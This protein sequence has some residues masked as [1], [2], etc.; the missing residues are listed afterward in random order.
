MRLD[1]FLVILFFFI[2]CQTKNTEV[3]K[4]DLMYS[5]DTININS[6]GRTL[7]LNRFLVV[8]DLD[9][10]KESIFSYNEFDHS[11]DEIDLNKLEFSNNYLFDREGSNG[12]GEYFL[13]FNLLKNNFFFIKSYNKSAV[14]DT[15]GVIV[16]KID[17]LNSVYSNG[18][19]YNDYPSSEIIIGTN[20]LRV[21]GL[22]YDN[23]K[24]EVYVDVLSVNRNIVK[25]L[26]LNFKKS[27]GDLVLEVDNSS[28]FFDPYVYLNT[29][30]NLVI[31]SHEF[32]NE[33]TLLSPN[34]EY[35]RT[36]SYV[37]NMTP[38][39]VKGFNSIKITSMEQLKRE[40]QY[41]LEQVE[42]YPPV[43]DDIKRRYFRL[44]IVRVFKEM[45][46]ADSFL[47]EI[48]DIKVYLSVFDNDF[49]LIA[50]SAIPELYYEEGKYFV[51]DGKL[52]VFQN[53]SDELGFIVIDVI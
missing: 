10:G 22:S 53:F 3:G 1:A 15:S 2:S 25:R 4:K 17:W 18:E 35:I 6:K 5:I 42:F 48:K 50:E 12:T 31:I 36:I 49:N 11:V 7:D 46:E 45:D 33:I 9:D 16:K 47:P 34:G 39:R 51:K 20:D 28:I 26:D 40:F 29:E 13:N 43:W 27:Y 8:S 14:F 24:R 23:S 52:W 30:N 21:Y 37:P 19:K 41:Y 38:K 32:S 44:S